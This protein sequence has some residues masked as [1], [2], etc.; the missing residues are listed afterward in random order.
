MSLKYL[1]QI[2]P[3]NSG[4][5]SDRDNSYSLGRKAFFNKIY[6]SKQI[7][8]LKQNLNYTNINLNNNNINHL[9]YTSL[10]NSFKGTIYAKPLPNKSNDLRIQ[11]IRLTAIGNGSTKLNS[12]NTF[13]NFNDYDKNFVNSKLKKVRSSGYIAPKIYSS[14]LN[15]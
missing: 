15:I 4:G 13:V 3:H 10:Q 9:N 14:S 1:S 8:N 12:P 2:N 5:I 11:N 6:E 7:N